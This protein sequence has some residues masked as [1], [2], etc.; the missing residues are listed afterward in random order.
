MN[1]ALISL[2]QIIS[3][4]YFDGLFFAS[5]RDLA[6]FDPPAKF[7]AVVP[8]HPPLSGFAGSSIAC[9]SDDEEAS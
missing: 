3:P 5:R 9:R 8:Q 2:F 4:H 6:I 7:M 1:A